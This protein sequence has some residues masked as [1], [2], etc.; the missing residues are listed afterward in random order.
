MSSNDRASST[1]RPPDAQ[2]ALLHE[3][4]AMLD[5]LRPRRAAAPVGLDDRI[6]QDLGLDSLSRVELILRIERAFDVQLPE[7]LLGEADTPR[8]L[9]GAVLAG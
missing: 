9:L 7:Q 8:D 1:A 5:E 3:I 6:E 2:A 4:R